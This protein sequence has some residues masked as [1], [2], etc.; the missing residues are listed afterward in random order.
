VPLSGGTTQVIDVPITAYDPPVL[1]TSS[2]GSMRATY[3]DPLGT[4]YDL[5]VTD[6]DHGYFTRPE[7]AGWGAPVFQIVT[8]PR[9]RGGETVRYIRQESA[10]ITWPLH[11]WGSTHQEFVTRYRAVR[12]G[13]LLTA[14]RTLPG[15]LRVAR[16]DGTAREI[17]VYYEEGFKGEP[18][19]NWLWA[20]PVLTLFAPDGAWRD[21][22]QTVLTRT[23]SA[24]GTNFFSPFPAISSSQ[25]L[26]STVLTN[27]GDMVAWPT[28][29]ITGPCT[30][31]T[32]ANTTLGQSFTLTTTLLTGEQATITTDRPT[33]RGPTGANLSGSLNWPGAVLWGL[34]PGDNQVTFTAAGSG[35]GTQVQ[36]SFYPRYEG[37]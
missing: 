8:D 25:V 16:P 28:W 4:V 7:I 23:Q 27:P 10:R 11:I 29:T 6:E 17:E 31:L 34:Q 37:V 26:G 5:S 1:W 13:F 21:T 9:P 3:T 2:V 35:T 32:A 33:V 30:A 15:V 24:S 18:G 22:D 14:H 12:R 19:E 36:L 20:N